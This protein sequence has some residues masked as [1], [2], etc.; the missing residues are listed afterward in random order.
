MNK[1]ILALIKLNIVNSPHNQAAVDVR[2]TSNKVYGL[3]RDHVEVVAKAFENFTSKCEDAC[4]AIL[5]DKK[6]VNLFGQRKLIYEIVVDQM[7]DEYVYTDTYPSEDPAYDFSRMFK[8]AEMNDHITNMINNL[9]GD[10]LCKI[11]YNP[12]TGKH[13]LWKNI[14]PNSLEERQLTM[15][16][17]MVDFEQKY[18]VKLSV[19]KV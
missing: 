7:K 15:H 18:G 12:L 8:F 16:K 10:K 14:V 19:K 2:E 9:S 3:I 17:E 5:N 1:N 4:F 11:G 13:F 6:T